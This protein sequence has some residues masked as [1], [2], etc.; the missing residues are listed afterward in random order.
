M[1]QA[2]TGKQSLSGTLWVWE[3]EMALAPDPSLAEATS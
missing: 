2:G 1:Q 3:G